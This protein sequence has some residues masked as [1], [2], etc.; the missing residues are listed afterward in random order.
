MTDDQRKELARDRMK[1]A[2][3]DMVTVPKELLLAVIQIAQI[4]SESL[5]QAGYN[6]SAAEDQ[7]RIDELYKA[8]G[9]K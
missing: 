6:T 7:A 8:A 5:D 1:A 2:G 9:F 4:D 3:Q